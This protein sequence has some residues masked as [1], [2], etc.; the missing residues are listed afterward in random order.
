MGVFEPVLLLSFGKFIL[1]RSG[2]H[3][4][5]SER[6]YDQFAAVIYQDL[7]L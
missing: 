3:F 7:F 2:F 4:S 1:M 6:S 5:K